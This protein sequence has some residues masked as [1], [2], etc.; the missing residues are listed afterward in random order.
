MDT[1][2]P[3]IEFDLN[4]HCN[5]CQ[6]YFTRIKEEIVTGDQ[7]ADE[8]SRIV[9]SIKRSGKDKDYDCVVGVSGGVDSSMVAWKV[10]EL[11]L[12]PLAIHFDNGWNSELAV[13]NIKTLLDTLGID[14]STYVVDWEEFRDLQLSFMRASVAN[15]EI[16]TDHAITSLSFQLAAKHG[17]KHII[18]GSNIRSEGFVPF[19]WG[20]YHQDLRHIRAIHRKFGKV[21]LRSTPCMSI[22]KWV[23]NVFVRRIKWFPILNYLDYDKAQAEKQLKEK[24][25]W[26]PY[27]GKHYESIYTRFFQGYYLPT[28]FGYDKRRAHLSCL[29]LGGEITREKALLEIKRDPYAD[30]D[31]NQD[32]DFFLKK[33][34]LSKEEFDKILTAPNKTYKNYPSN[35]LLFRRMSFLRN[36]LKKT[37][38]KVS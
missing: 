1:S 33:M 3:D 6:N 35:D 17:I 7:G 34:K 11:G 30:N 37:V 21:P 16:P 28:K 38:K 32:M 19:S 25:G 4:G 20:Y 31:L 8:L 24:M 13:A 15:L 36:F 14:L 5:H 26:R 29:V 10:K 18:V 22:S 9:D 23:W 2:D 12:R 27:G